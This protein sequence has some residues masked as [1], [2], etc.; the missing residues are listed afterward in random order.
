MKSADFSAFFLPRCRLHRWLSVLKEQ[1]ISSS[2]WAWNLLGQACSHLYH[3][4][5]F[6]TTEARV[7][8][9][10]SCFQHKGAQ[11]REVPTATLTIHLTVQGQRVRERDQVN[12]CLPWNEVTDKCNNRKNREFFKNTCSVVLNFLAHNLKNCDCEVVRML[13]ALI[14]GSWPCKSEA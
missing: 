7:Q 1:H 11:S 12:Q 3:A 8:W 5:T 4:T 14:I 6:L 2:L 10:N 9:A 13:K